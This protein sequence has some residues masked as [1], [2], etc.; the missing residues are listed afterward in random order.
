MRRRPPQTPDELALVALDF[1]RAVERAGLRRYSKLMGRFPVGC[2]K[3]ASQLLAKYLVT[4]LHTPLVTFVYAERGGG[5][6]GDPW[7][8]HV[9]LSVGPHTLDITADQYP[10]IDAPVLVGAG[11]DDWHM[12]WPRQRRLTYG[13]MMRFDF[14]DNVRFRRMY[15]SVMRSM[16]H[17]P[18]P[19]LQFPLRNSGPPA[20][21]A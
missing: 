17:R 10:E 20:E 1:R 18:L 21:F 12:D 8:S 3:G 6:P 5:G 13:E 2:C 4:E 15:R 14:W 9:W 16:H 11:Q 7:Q 19:R